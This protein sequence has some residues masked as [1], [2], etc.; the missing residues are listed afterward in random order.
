MLHMKSPCVLD[1]SLVY[2]PIKQSRHSTIGL[3]KA[4][5]ER[6]IP[7]SIWTLCMVL[8]EHLIGEI[9]FSCLKVTDVA[10]ISNLVVPNA[11]VVGHIFHHWY[12]LGDI[13]RGVHPVAKDALIRRSRFNEGTDY[14]SS[15][16]PISYHKASPEIAEADPSLQ[17]P[18][19]C[20]ACPLNRD[21]TFEI[22]HVAI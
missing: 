20:P 14:R 5:F 21:P 3:V 1:C 6:E 13:I 9:G 16:I 19:P 22:V 10:T 7:F 15:G 17:L 18:R 12:I 4:L 11:S 2:D 8:K